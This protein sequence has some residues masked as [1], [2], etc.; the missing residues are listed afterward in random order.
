MDTSF[1]LLF[2]GF[3]QKTV[4]CYGHVGYFRTAEKSMCIKARHGR[5]M[6]WSINVKL[7]ISQA[8]SLCCLIFDVLSSCGFRFCQ[9]NR[10]LS[11]P[12]A[13]PFTKI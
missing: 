7:K 13:Y 3:N 9:E 6:Q 1:S 4:A 5:F 10:P 12:T 11:F 2:M 8:P